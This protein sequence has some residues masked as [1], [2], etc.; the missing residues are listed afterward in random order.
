MGQDE[1]EAAQAKR[2][3]Q[4]ATP[5]AKSTGKGGTK[6]KGTAGKEP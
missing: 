4:A 5:A 1:L 6:R 2:A 3:V